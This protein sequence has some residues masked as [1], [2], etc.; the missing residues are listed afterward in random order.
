MLSNNLPTTRRKPFTKAKSNALTGINVDAYL[1]I[2]SRHIARNVRGRVIDGSVHLSLIDLIPNEM[3]EF[4]E[5]GQLKVGTGYMKF[6]RRNVP[7]TK[8]KIRTPRGI[9]TLNVVHSDNVPL[10]ATY[11]YYKAQGVDFRACYSG[12]PLRLQLGG[13]TQAFNQMERAFG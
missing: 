8:A 6:L 9:R 1:G 2:M 12:L 4:T 3:K 10:V 7:L 5:R 11:V 13:L